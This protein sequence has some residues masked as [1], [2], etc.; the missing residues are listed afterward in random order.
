MQLWADGNRFPTPAPGTDSDRRVVQRV[1]GLLILLGLELEILRQWLNAAAP[2][3]HPTL[4]ALLLERGSG[5]LRFLVVRFTVAFALVSLAF[6]DARVTAAPRRIL[7]DLVRRP[8]HSQLLLAH[9]VLLAL[10]V[11]LSSFLFDARPSLPLDF[12]LT[13]GWLVT[14]AA[15]CG[16]VVLAFV[17]AAFWVEVIRSTR[18]VLAF[19]VLVSAGGFVSSQLALTLWQPLSRGT[20]DV[21]YAILHP[22]VDN[23]IIDPE[24][25]ILGSPGF[26]VE[27]GAPCSGYDGLGLILVFAVAWLWFH[28]AEWR[29][30]HALILIPAGL[31]TIWLINCARVAALVL[32]GIAGAPDI[33]LGG[34]HTQAGWLGFTAVALGICLGARRVPWL[35]K[36]ARSAFPSESEVTN[37]VAAYLVPFLA[38]L[39]GS[40]VAQLASGGFEWLCPIRVVGSLAALWYFRERYRTLNW[41]FGWTSIALGG[42]VFVIW[43]ALEPV[44][45]PVQAGMPLP[46]SQAPAFARVT[47]LVIR[48]VG[49]VVTVPMAEEL[50]FRGFLLRQFG[51]RDFESV[52]RQSVSWTAILLSSLAFGALHGERWLPAV[53]AGVAYAVAVVRRGSIGD[54][55]AAHATTNALIA[56]AVLFWGSWQLW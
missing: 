56:A 20:M 37:P 5:T 49:S 28:R 54:A 39:A 53:L 2:Q 30:P 31:A 3:D 52:R 51:S 34:F 22:F 16:L 55:I 40:M 13:G 38:I 8:I 50:A 42:F 24:N 6:I 27:I 17:P 15:A 43:M 9:F 10:F 46:L 1:G 19:A 18:H 4:A 45:T 32:V 14:G 26:Q 36:D 47:W 21:A 48:V 23:L 33:A 7:V 29:F 11:A 44:V 25:F 35:L 41:R 12:A